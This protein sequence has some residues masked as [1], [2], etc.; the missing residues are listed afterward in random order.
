[1]LSIFSNF[2]GTRQ[3]RLLKKMEPLV[4]KINELE[5]GIQALT[6]DQLRGQTVLF[7]DRLEKG[8]KL[9]GLLPEAYATVREASRRTLGMRHFDVQLLGGIALHQ[10]KIAEMRTGEGKTLVAT[11]PA[12]LNALSGKGVHVVTVNDY[13][14]R[15]DATTMSAV[16]GAL[17]L[18][19]G[20]V[21]HNQPREE[22][23][24]AYSADIT[25][26]TNNEFGFDYLRDNLV[27][28]VGDRN[29]R[30]LSYAII[31]EVDSILIDEARTP[32]IISGPHEESLELYQQIDVLASRLSRQETEEGAG[33]F[34]LDEKTRGV[35]LSEAG[36]AKVDDLLAE[37][38]L[39]PED[40]YNARHLTL[41]QHVN[42]ALRARHA[43]LRDKDYIVRDGKVVIVDEFTGRALQGRRWGEGLHQ[44]V[45]AK[46]RVE[47]LPE[48]QPVASVTLQN[49]FR[50]YEKLSGMTGTA[51]TEAYE[52]QSI[53]G[54][55]VVVIPTHRPMI[56]EDREDQVYLT[57]EG[58]FAA[59]AREIA[60]CHARNQPV[61]V[62]TTSIEVSE[63]LSERLKKLK[64]PHEVLNAKQHEREA[65]II[66]GAGAP[67]AIT[68][69]TNMAGR[70]TD[71]VLGG[72][73]DA[74]ADENARQKWKEAH[75]KAYE[76]GGLHV[77]GTERH[78]SRRIDNQLRGRS[79]RQG[80]PGSSR[81]FL[82]LEDHL[83]KVFMPKWSHDALVKM[84]MSDERP[85]EAKVISKQVENAQKKIEGFYFDQRKELLEYD[86]VA[87]QQRQTI[88]NHRNALLELEDPGQDIEDMVQQ[89][90][91]EL[92]T[93]HFLRHPLDAENVEDL[94]KEVSSHGVDLDNR[95]LSHAADTEATLSFE[96]NRQLRQFMSL[97]EMMWGEKVAGQAYR[98]ALLLAVDNAW[99]EQLQAMDMLRR[100]IHLRAMAQ[101]KPKEEYRRE[102]FE[103]FSHL[104]ASLPAATLEFLFRYDHIPS[105]EDNEEGN[106]LVSGEMKDVGVKPTGS[107]VDDFELKF[108]TE[109]PI[110][111]NDLCPCGS[112][113]KYK[114][115]HGALKGGDR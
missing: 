77:I 109:R 71:I 83:L 34:Y 87:N 58:K 67:G 104:T 89:W 62:G 94:V 53:Y 50:S 11:L 85:I 73:L 35:S 88:Y 13:L 59:V 95:A 43:Y 97:K 14:A 106:V 21:Y 78:E 110:S 31:D 57:K 49:Y 30:G 74:G 12:Y 60:E 69:A 99:R 101:K 26:G 36:Q 86:D 22:K 52:L 111:R 8:E 65:G 33:D 19:T 2:F 5:P 90:S 41:L 46:E 44:A 28:E 108:V 9:D 107:G 81:F 40:T 84:G 115:C 76:A 18:T 72:H 29:Q 66:A 70:G 39:L 17:G 82:S 93:S 112:G 4:A 10:G 1:M 68:I 24:V 79:G 15:R 92:A 37:M 3:S 38:G 20:V 75:E 91:D 63:N 114:H 16:F 61:L 80:D 96:I 48:D 64:L 100:G 54:L 47:V 98:A 6:D 32:L 105:Q 56:R 51:D 7:K 113:K 103:L 55:E 25:Y 45:E 27:T 23:G 42:A 102:A